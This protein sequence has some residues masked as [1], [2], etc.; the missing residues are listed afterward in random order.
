MRTPKLTVIA[1]LMLGSSLTIGSASPAVGDTPDIWRNLGGPQWCLFY[2]PNAAPPGSVGNVYG[3][4]SCSAQYRGH[5]WH[6][7][8]I[9]DSPYYRIINTVGGACLTVFGEPGGSFADIMAAGCREDNGRQY[10]ELT[11]WSGGRY[12]I[13][14]PWFDLCLTTNTQASS[15]VYL[16][17]C[18][19]GNPYQEWVRA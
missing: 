8:G 5:L 6:S 10:W 7:H 1:L 12:T 9:P 13:K 17:R 2:D 3:T 15:D 11:R 19:G 14:N 4:P 18:P 16:A